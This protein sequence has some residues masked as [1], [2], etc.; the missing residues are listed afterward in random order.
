MRKVIF[1]IVFFPFFTSA[2]KLIGGKSII[3]VN[4][5]SL[6]LNNYQLTYERKVANRVSV[7][8]GVRV[9]PTSKV[10]FRS[11][12]ETY[13]DN[14]N[15]DLTNVRMRN[16][17]VT[18]ECRLYLKNNMHGFYAAPYLRYA[19]FNIAAPI[20]YTFSGS[21]GYKNKIANFSGTINSFSG[22]VMIG[23][24]YQLL[25]KLVIDIWIVGGHYGISKGTLNGTYIAETTSPD[26]ENERNSLQNILSGIY[27]SPFEAKGTVNAPVGTQGTA[28][29]TSSGPWAGIRAAGINLGFRF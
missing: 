22:G 3:K 19:S 23:T 16:F 10:P 15:V 14:P 5:S 25:K 6:A 4:L 24:Q 27:A 18:P 21:N 11:A 20:N 9:M 26:K 29:I 17:A 7:S 1:F 12:I 28:V 2:Q 13:L 8:L